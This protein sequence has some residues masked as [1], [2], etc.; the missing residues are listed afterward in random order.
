MSTEDTPTIDFVAAIP[1]FPGCQRF[2]L[3]RLDDA[4]LI[5]QL[6]SI[7]EEEVRFL[8]VP[9]FPF[10]PEYTPTIDDDTLDLL[11]V[12]DPAQ[13]LILLVVTVGATAADATANLF[14]PIVVD[15]ASGRAAQAVLTGSRFPI[16][17]P[18]VTTPT[19]AG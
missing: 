7:E 17:A 11:G 4:G 18:L 13:L 3:V 6:T 1:G 15:Q 8:V 10:F 14:A 9:P 2:L 5:F 12:H 16:S 19:G